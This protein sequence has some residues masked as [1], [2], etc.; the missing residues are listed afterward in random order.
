M[1]KL[2]PHRNE[3]FVRQARQVLQERAATG[4]GMTAVHAALRGM[5]DTQTDDT[6]K[7]RAMWC[8]HVTGGASSD[9]LQR[10]LGHASEHVRVWAIQLLLDP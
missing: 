10:Q 6:R 8:L 9:W 4:A 2:Q 1:V 3:W 5:F 7:L